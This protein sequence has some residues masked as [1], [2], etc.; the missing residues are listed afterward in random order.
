MIIEQT[1]STQAIVKEGS[2]L[3][4]HVS[5]WNINPLSYMSCLKITFVL[6]QIAIKSAATNDWHVFL[7]IKFGEILWSIKK[8]HHYGGPFYL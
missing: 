4:V 2:I 5:E 7:A 8:A 3:M 1:L 6:F